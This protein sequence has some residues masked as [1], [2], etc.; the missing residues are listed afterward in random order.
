MYKDNN[1]DT[2]TSSMTSF[3]I[4]KFNHI[5]NLF[6]LLTLKIYL[7]AEKFSLFFAAL[8]IYLGNIFFQNES[9]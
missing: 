6:L 8:L 4:V 5:S 2:R 1:K 9:C 7:F 3:F